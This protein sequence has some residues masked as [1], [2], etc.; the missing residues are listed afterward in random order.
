MKYCLINQ[1]KVKCQ[2]G[3]ALVE[4]ALVLPIFVIV[5]FGIIE[6]ARLWET[7]NILTSAAREGVRVAAVTPPDAARVTTAA[8][9]ILNAANITNTVIL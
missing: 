9:N 6:F 2:K 1:K 3:Q 8:N 5:L 7:V 4:F